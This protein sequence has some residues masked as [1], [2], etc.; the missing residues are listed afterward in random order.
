MQE[1]D[2]LEHCIT[3]TKT[4]FLYVFKNETVISCRVIFI[5]TGIILKQSPYVTWQSELIFERYILF[6]VSIWIE[7]SLIQLIPR[8]YHVYDGV[9]E[10]LI[11][12]QSFCR[13]QG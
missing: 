6:D 7:S 8:L 2:E 12:D 5:F 9:S 13:G 1:T 4:V 3:T 10:M 11:S